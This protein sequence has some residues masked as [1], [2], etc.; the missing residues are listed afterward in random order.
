MTPTF[1]SKQEIVSTVMKAG[2]QERT[3]CTTQTA[4]EGDN[5]HQQSQ[6]MDPR[7]CLPQHQAPESFRE[8]KAKH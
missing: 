4:T 2:S 7:L 5:A 8:S 1:P 6:S 3:Q